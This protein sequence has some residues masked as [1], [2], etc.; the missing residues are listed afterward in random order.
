MRPDRGGDLES[1]KAVPVRT[2]A[3]LGGQRRGAEMAGRMVKAKGGGQGMREVR[4]LGRGRIRGSP[5]PPKATKAR[6]D[7][8][9]L[10]RSKTE[11]S[12]DEK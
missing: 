4:E 12:D 2:S 3:A 11:V 5:E 6:R 9:Y 1:G 7:D 10:K 8:D